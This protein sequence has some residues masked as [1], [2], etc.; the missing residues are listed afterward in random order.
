MDK[1]L[2]EYNTWVDKVQ[3]SLCVEQN[4]SDYKIARNEF[5][6]VDELLSLIDYRR[7]VIDS[8]LDSLMYIQ[9]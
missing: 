4:L 3:Q 5:N 1:T 2:E 7:S 6:T 8:I 9:I